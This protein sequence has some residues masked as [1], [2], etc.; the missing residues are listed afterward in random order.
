MYRIIGKLQGVA[1]LLYNRPVDFQ[2]PTPPA[3]EAKPAKRNKGGRVSPEDRIADAQEKVYRDENG[4]YIPG[5]NF[6]VC[7]VAGCKR[8]GLKEGRGS[9]APYFEATIFPEHR[10]YFGKMQADFMHEHWGRVPPKTGACVM[11]RRPALNTG[12]VLSFAVNC[13]DDRLKSEDIRRALDEAGLL[14]GL[15]SWRP[16]YGRFIVTQFDVEEM[17]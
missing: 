7:L 17:E 4:L 6:K 14:V 13:V 12:W 1:P 15:G 16:E 8:A 11:V 2:P 9:K 5:W 3:G 10:L